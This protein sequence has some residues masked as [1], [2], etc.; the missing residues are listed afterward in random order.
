MEGTLDESFRGCLDDLARREDITTGV[1]MTPDSQY[2]P[3]SI[4]RFIASVL[5]DEFAM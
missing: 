3:I 5:E 1:V 4:E 2:Y